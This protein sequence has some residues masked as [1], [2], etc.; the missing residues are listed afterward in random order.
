MGNPPQDYSLRR[1]CRSFMYLPFIMYGYAATLLLLLLGCQLVLHAIP[2]LRG[3]RELRWAIACAIAAVALVGLRPWAPAFATI[4]L[5]NY[6]LFASFLL[7]YWTTTR[8]LKEKAAFLKWGIAL[9][10]SILPG[11]AY[12]TWIRPNIAARI[13]MSSGG[14][15]VIC[16]ATAAVLFRHRSAELTRSARTLAWLQMG[17]ALINAARCLLTVLHPPRDFVRGDWVQTGF[18]YAQLILC[19]GTCCGIVWLSL[20]RNRARLE[21]MALRDSMTG[22]LNRRAL[23]EILAHELGESARSGQKFGVILLD[24]DWFK[25]INDTYGH[26]AGDQA[27]RRVSAILQSET[28]TGDALARYGGEEFILVVRNTTLEQTHMIAERIRASIQQAT[29]LPSQIRLTASIGAAISGGD[30]SAQALINR[31]D[32][33]LYHSKKSGRNLVTLWSSALESAVRSA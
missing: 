28:R 2:G 18:T 9:C 25:T 15:A 11:F 6:A 33:A 3:I 21:S 7:I 17:N 27:I 24:L 4:L 26:F 8:V 14:V 20:I 16:L 30:E 19:V 12:A 29:D 1:L 13:V 23:D 32:L 5:G 22:L 31:C 10:A